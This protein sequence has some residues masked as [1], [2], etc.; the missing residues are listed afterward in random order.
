[1]QLKYMFVLF[2]ILFLG[3]KVRW[4]RGLGRRRS[5]RGRRGGCGCRCRVGVGPSCLPPHMRRAQ[6][7]DGGQLAGLSTHLSGHS[8]ATGGSCHTGVTLRKHLSHAGVRQ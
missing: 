4:R 7:V 5:R 6:P 8:A 1:M 2:A 3:E